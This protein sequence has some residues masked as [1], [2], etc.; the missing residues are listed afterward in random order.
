MAEPLIQKSQ[1]EEEEDRSTSFSSSSSPLESYHPS[2]VSARSILPQASSSS[3]CSSANSQ[4]Q[5]GE[6]E[7]REEARRE[8]RDRSVNNREQSGGISSSSSS[9]VAPLSLSPLILRPVSM[10]PV[11]AL[12]PQVEKTSLSFLS[13]CSSYPFH[14]LSFF[15][16]FLSGSWPRACFK[17]TR[18][19]YG[20]LFTQP[21]LLVSLHAHRLIQ[22]RLDVDRQRD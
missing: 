3:S 11:I 10:T 15:L 8:G 4:R 22:G 5:R 14:L 2:Q 9:T 21:R 12:S 6:G 1:R 17:A 18:A 7:G 16:P 13:R 20:A 19:V